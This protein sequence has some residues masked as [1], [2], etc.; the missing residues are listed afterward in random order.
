MR[1]FTILAA[2][3]GAAAA[4][5]ISIFNRA[6]ATDP[7][8]FTPATPGGIEDI[9]ITSKNTLNATAP[10]PDETTTISARALTANLPMS[11]VNN[12]S[13]GKVNAYIQGLDSDGRI[14]F[15]T[16]G[17]KLV[18]PS[19]GGS[20]VPV[21]I[22]ADL[23]IPMSGKGSALNFNLP[24]V[25]E[26]GRVYFAEGNLQFFMVSI[27]GGK[28]GLVQPS[29]A[30]PSDP[31]AN[32]NWGFVEFTFTRDK[33]VFANI[34]YVDFVGLSLGT[35]LEV[36]GGATQAAQ[37]LV[38]GAVQSI[39]NDLRAQQNADG[40]AWAALCVADSSGR[41]VRAL[42]PILYTDI[43]PNTFANY[44]QGYVDQVWSAY[45][46]RALT[47]DTQ[48]SAGK[49]QCRVA[50]NVMTCP[51]DNKSYAKPS[52]KDIWGCN[53]G[54][55]GKDGSENAVHLAVIPRLCAA[56]YRSTLLLAGGDVQ[57]SLPSSKYYTVNPT[58]HYGRL[59]HKYEPDGKGYAFSYD[60]VNP[61]GENASGTVSSGNVKLLT[62]TIA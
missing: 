21:K 18:Y 36:N 17:G 48:M 43:N 39:C 45:A 8:G 37:G 34:S 6:P 23:A 7:D 24:I 14:V 46:S 30:N 53:S 47:I 35:K 2:L 20:T 25:L 4:S 32:I 51:G 41:P 16:S 19:S 49:I 15:V 40:R 61:D 1:P 27:G 42:A 60:D 62:F 33:V 50:N 10:S 31:S 57:P 54:P 22:N 28:D 59:V 5:P 44:W 13:G 58:S 26:S 56:F 52:A 38:T 9:V 12:F 11:F 3:L 55:F 29:A